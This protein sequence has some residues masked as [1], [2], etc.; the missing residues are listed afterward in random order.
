[1]T[2]LL[3]SV[4]KGGFLLYRYFKVP[5][6]FLKYFSL[7]LEGISKGKNIYRYSLENA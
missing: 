7:I 5:F 1:M 3:L 4:K 6:W 2:K